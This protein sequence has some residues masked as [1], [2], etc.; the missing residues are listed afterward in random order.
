I[1]VVSTGAE[2]REAK[3]RDLACSRQG[4]STSLRYARGD[5][6]SPPLLLLELRQRLRDDLLA[7]L[8][9]AQEGDAVDLAGVV[10][11]GLDQDAGRLVGRDGHAVQRRG[12]RLAVELARLLRRRLDHVGRDVALHAVMVG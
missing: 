1:S 9:L 2:Q 4:P 11:A 7:V 3:R 6:S 10:P 12:D 8:D 5:G